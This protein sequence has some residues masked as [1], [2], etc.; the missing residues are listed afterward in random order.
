[1]TRPGGVE[2][3]GEHLVEGQVE[4]AG[5]G[6]VG[7]EDDDRLG[8]ALVDLHLGRA[9][10]RAADVAGEGVGEEVLARAVELE[11]LGELGAG[12]E[13]VPGQLVD[14]G[15]VLAALVGHDQEHVV[16][17]VGDVVIDKKAVLAGLLQV[18]T[19][20]VE[21]VGVGCGVADEAADVGLDYGNGQ[22]G[23]WGDTSM[24]VVKR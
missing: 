23:H 15:C 21:D 3:V 7:H 17:A 22:T 5:G 10:A 11:L 20:E 8:R 4:G 2:G 19:A 18:L 24:C 1:M 14:L 6:L 13:R 16:A 12:D 9:G